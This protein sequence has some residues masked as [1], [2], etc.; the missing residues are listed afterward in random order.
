MDK[1]EIPL[2]KTKM[3]LVVMGS[4]LFVAFGVFCVTT[5]ADNQ[6]RYLPAYVKA[7]G[8][9]SVSFFS[10]TGIYGFWK[11]FDN[12]AGLTIDKTG[13][14]DNS[15][16]GAIG[17]IRWVDVTG[18][19]T[20]QISSTK[21]LLI[22]VSNPEYYLDKVKG[23]KRMGLNANYKRYG[24]PLCIASVALKYDFSALERLMYDRFGDVQRAAVV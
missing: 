13:I 24:T 20:I 2:S 18:I 11:L 10:L 22:H 9:L 14:L 3:L 19:E 21:L 12:K 15:S 5:L 8:I 16:G 7:V 23:I 17:L 6:T 4:L 1:V